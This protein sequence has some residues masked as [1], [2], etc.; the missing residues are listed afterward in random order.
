MGCGDIQQKLKT[1][2]LVKSYTHYLDAASKGGFL[3]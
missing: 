1:V 3:R 2:A